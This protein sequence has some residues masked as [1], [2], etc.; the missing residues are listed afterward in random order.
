MV[1]GGNFSRHVDQ[2]IVTKNNKDIFNLYFLS[3]F[4]F[5]SFFLFPCITRQSNL[6]LLNFEE[7]LALPENWL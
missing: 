3:L 5:F 7:F 4:L 2:D 6:Q 1:L